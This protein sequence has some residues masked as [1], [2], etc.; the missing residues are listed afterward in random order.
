[1]LSSEV[2]EMTRAIRKDRGEEI[3]QKVLNNLER[4][5]L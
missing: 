1:M 4:R 3:K 2:M 5:K